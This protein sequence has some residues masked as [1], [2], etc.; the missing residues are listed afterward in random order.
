MR[1]SADTQEM[2][3]EWWENFQRTIKG[4]NFS[5]NLQSYLLKMDKTI[6]TLALIFELCEGGRFKINRDALERALYWGKY[7]IS[8]AKLLYA[9]GDTLTAERAKLI[10]KRC[11]HLSYILD[12][13]IIF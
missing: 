5:T 9:A 7:L 3:R 1:F 4:G 13:G 8:H 10:I 11:D 12:Y 6:P 2:F